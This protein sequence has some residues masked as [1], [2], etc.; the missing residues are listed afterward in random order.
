MVLILDGILEIGVHGWSDLGYLIYLGIWLDREQ[1]QIWF[2]S[3]KKT[4]F[5]HSCAT[6]SD[7]PYSKNYHTLNRQKKHHAAFICLRHK[8]WN[9][10]SLTFVTKKCSWSAKYFTPW[11][12][13]I[14]KTSKFDL[15]NQNL[16]F[17]IF[18]NKIFRN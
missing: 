2:L 14:K 1:P 9:F 5:L 16:N 8:N 10:Y 17:W 11:C 4:C 12:D 6:C 18:S 3:S 13:N 15:Q 7:L